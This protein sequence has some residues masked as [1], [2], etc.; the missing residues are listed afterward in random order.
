MAALSLSLGLASLWVVAAAL[1]ALLPMRAQFPP[2]IVL[3]ALVPP[4]LGYI[5]YQHGIWIT[6]LALLAVISMF[7]RPL[8]HLARFVLARARTGPVQKEPRQ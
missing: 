7:R 5:G 4:L 6:L 3:L 1:V 8:Q 2:G